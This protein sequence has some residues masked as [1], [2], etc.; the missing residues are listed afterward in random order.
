[1][2]AIRNELKQISAYRLAAKQKAESAKYWHIRERARGREQAFKTVEKRL[3]RL[4]A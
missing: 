4:L 3:L 1:M 2:D